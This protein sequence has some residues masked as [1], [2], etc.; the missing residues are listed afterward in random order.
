MLFVIARR[1]LLRHSR[2][3]ALFPRHLE[4]FRRDLQLHREGDRRAA[5]GAPDHRA[6]RSTSRSPASSRS[7]R[8]RWGSRPQAG[9]RT[10]PALVAI[11]PSARACLRRVQWRPRRLL[12][13]ALDRRDD[14]HD[15]PVPR[16]RL[17]VLGDQ[18]LKNYPAE[19]CLLRP[20]LC[21]WA[22]L[23]RVRALPRR[24]VVAGI[25]LHATTASGGGSSPSATTR[26]PRCFPASPST[27]IASS[28]S[29]QS[30]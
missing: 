27:A 5:A 3:L 8:S 26:S 30:G 13:R 16:R 2:R 11:G 25:V 21:R 23:L 1:G 17:C 9:R 22:A 6:A 19:L 12:P 15:E 24:R 10:P 18:V 20:G 14:R 28:C 4:P 7:L 29:P